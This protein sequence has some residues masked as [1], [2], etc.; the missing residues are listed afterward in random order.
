MRFVGYFVVVVVLL[1]NFNTVL[2][3]LAPLHETKHSN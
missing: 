2:Q 3:P 1:Y